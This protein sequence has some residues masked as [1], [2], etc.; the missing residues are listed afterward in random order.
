MNLPK[1]L[2]IRS[3]NSLLQDLPPKKFFLKRKLFLPIFG[4]VFVFLLILGV[5]FSK[6]I[7]SFL[8]SLGVYSLMRN[9]G[10][11]RPSVPKYFEALKSQNLVYDYNN[12]G[13]VTGED[14]DPL[15]TDVAPETRVAETSITADTADEVLAEGD[16]LALPS[17]RGFDTDAFSGS[18]TASYPIESPQGT[19]GLTPSLSLNYS[20]SA[21]DDLYVGTETK[22]RNDA[23]H[24]YQRQAGNFG[25]GWNLSGLGSI[26]RDDNG[27]LNELSD[28]KFILSFSGG[29]ADLSK[30]S[31]DNTYSIWR[32]VPN[33]KV[34]VERFGG[35]K[36][37]NYSGGS[38]SICR[39]SWQVTT[40]D[41]T[42]YYFGA[43]APVD[44]WHRANDPDAAYLSQGSGSSW[45]PL[46]E[47]VS[48]QFLGATTWQIYGSSAKGWH[49]FSNRW[50]V[51]KVESVFD[52]AGGGNVEINF[53]Y[54]FELGKYQ[55]KKYVRAFYPYK[56]SY[57][58]NEIEFTTEP[59]LDYLIHQGDNAIIK[60]PFEAQKRISRIIVKSLNKVFRA[61]TLN[62]KYGWEPTKHF[63]DGDGFA[64]FIYE[65]KDG[66][67]IH[68]LLTGVTPWNDNPPQPTPTPPP[69]P[70]ANRVVGLRGLYYNSIDIG[71]NYSF[72]RIDPQ[73]QFDWGSG[74]PN[75]SSLGNDTYSIFW[76]GDLKVASGGTYT[77]YTVSDDGVKLWINNQ[78]I[79]DNWTNHAP[80]TNS[81]SINLIPGENKVKLQYYESSGGAIIRL[82]WS[83]P[84]ITTQAIPSSNLSYCPFLAEYFNEEGFRSL[85][86]T[87]IDNQIQF[88]WGTGFPVSGVDPDSFSVR[89]TGVVKPPQDGDYTFTTT[90]DDGVRLFINDQLLIDNWTL[91]VSTTDTESI[92]LNANQD[93]YIRL[94]YFDRSGGATMRLSWNGPGISFSHGGDF[95]TCDRSQ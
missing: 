15:V 93:Y 24:P 4:L 1:P 59:R 51:S 30:E 5:V 56:I 26:T 16:K 80:T 65:V 57:G 54:V 64:E 23:N 88:D 83:G 85:I 66:Q 27:T 68:S 7:S 61:Y 95:L 38:L 33:L 21:V 72:A 19:A 29:S 12:D 91:H 86:K 9:L 32:T 34:R 89:W 47:D 60:Q 40:S 84:G 31:G 58:S 11:L 71:T 49:A 82:N 79:I 53:S 35:C 41:G 78:L 14:Y 44:N 67:V 18:S 50:L 81:A 55:G 37:Y 22:W 8:G 94:E 36:T 42:K 2:S 75:Y 69:S 76:A 92:H 48:G 73:I 3:N 39:Y 74:S 28:D 77:F 6:N 46:Y 70:L 52:G 43:L 20:S 62:Y 45:Y 13:S 63:D 10:L 87:Q 90:S 25:L 17:L